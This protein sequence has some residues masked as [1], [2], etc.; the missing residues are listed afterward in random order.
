MTATT[1]KTC[2]SSSPCRVGTRRL[3]LG[4]V[5]LSG[6]ARS[7]GGL[8]RPGAAGED[9]ES[10]VLDSASGS[11]TCQLWDCGQ[12]QGAADSSVISETAGLLPATW[13]Q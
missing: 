12:T 6:T 13:Q 9:E 3:R 1:N 8:A 11:A 4:H 5:S 2:H 7:G 10:T